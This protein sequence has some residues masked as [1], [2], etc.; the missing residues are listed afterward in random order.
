MLYRAF[1]NLVV[2]CSKH[3]RPNVPSIAVPGKVE[4][5]D[6]V[7]NSSGLIF[8]PVARLLTLDI[9]ISWNEPTITNG[10]I[11]NYEVSVTQTDNSSDVVYSNDSLLVSNVTVSMMVVPYTN[12]T[13]TVAA[14]TSAGQGEST[15]ITRLSPEASTVTLC[16]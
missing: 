16:C 3:L 1:I 13:V 11:L 7:F 5:L 15:N 6:A 4:D 2:M 10:E 8:D 9:E 12:Y 14:S